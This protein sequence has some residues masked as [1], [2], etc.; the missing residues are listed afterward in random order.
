MTKMY[1]IFVVSSLNIKFI[2]S[3]FLKFMSHY[4]GKFA[5]AIIY[6]KCVSYVIN[7]VP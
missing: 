5:L 7:F 2:I 1:G 3:L 4:Y 6:L